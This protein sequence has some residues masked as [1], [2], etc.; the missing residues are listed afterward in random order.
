MATYNLWL[1]AVRLR[2]LRQRA[3]RT[4]RLG[5]RRDLNYGMI[6]SP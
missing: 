3:C 1:F 5:L 6:G 4:R 2:P